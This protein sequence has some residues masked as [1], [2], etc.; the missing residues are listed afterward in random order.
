MKKLNLSK[1]LS[2]F[3]LTIMFM[4]VFENAPVDRTWALKQVQHI[5]IISNNFPL[6]QNQLIVIGYD[7]EGKKNDNEAKL[8]TGSQD[9]IVNKIISYFSEPRD[10]AN[11][12]ASAKPCLTGDI[13]CCILNS[14]SCVPVATITS[15]IDSDGKPIPFGGVSD[16]REITFIFTSL[17]RF[18]AILFEC[19]L[20]RSSFKPCTSPL[21]VNSNVTTP[22]I[23]NSSRHEL[24]IRMS[25]MDPEDSPWARFIWF[26]DYR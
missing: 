3:L 11:N 18:G 16:S 23:N 26:S 7:Q 19:S 20:D 14:K 10:L 21:T 25:G 1:A 2:L 13:R 17:V 4:L 22:P 5:V 9:V 15:V 12:S 24:E 8:T 6:E